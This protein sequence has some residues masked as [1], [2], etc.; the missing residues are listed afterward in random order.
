MLIESFERVHL[1]L[2]NQLELA[3]THVEGDSPG[4]AVIWPI[5]LSPGKY[6]L[7]S[8]IDSCCEDDVAPWSGVP[9]A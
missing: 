7:A 9:I 1:M 8:S 5:G 3:Y 4:R 2:P 6:P